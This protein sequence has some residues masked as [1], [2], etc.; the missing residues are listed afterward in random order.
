MAKLSRDFQSPLDYQ[1]IQNLSRIVLLKKKPSRTLRSVDQ[2][3]LPRVLQK[4]YRVSIVPNFFAT[5]LCICMSDILLAHA[6]QQSFQNLNAFSAQLFISVGC[7]DVVWEVHKKA[8][9]K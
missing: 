3:P 7:S 1:L 9:V 4:V 8:R 2:K 5:F 6:G